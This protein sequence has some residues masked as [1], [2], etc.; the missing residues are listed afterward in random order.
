MV[1]TPD[2]PNLP[3]VERKGVKYFE[4]VA[5]PVQREILPGLFI[6]GWGYNGSVP[7][8]TIKVYPGDYVNIRV[9]NKLPEPTSLLNIGAATLARAFWVSKGKRF[10]K[11][12]TK[13][14]LYA[15]HYS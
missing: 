15:H 9:Y 1:I 7:G 4:L 13:K 14:D 11:W 2:V 5:E 6:K 3:F 12:I 10:I 8:P